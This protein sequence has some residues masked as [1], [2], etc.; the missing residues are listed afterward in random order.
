[1][2]GSATAACSS[3]LAASTVVMASF[4]SSDERVTK[5][6]GDGGSVLLG[7]GKD[8]AVGSGVGVGIT[9][10]AVGGS[11]DGLGDGVGTGDGSEV[12]VSSRGGVS[13][14]DVAVGWRVG[15]GRG[16]GEAVGVVGSIVAVTLAWRLAD[17]ELPIAGSITP[18]STAAR[19]PQT[20][21]QNSKPNSNA[22]MRPVTPLRLGLRT[23]GPIL[24]LPR[25]AASTRNGPMRRIVRGSMTTT[26]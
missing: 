26:R 14:V 6:V 18:L 17:G 23:I 16:V 5:G 19:P 25:S 3:S 7:S 11:G 22:P 8:V 4:T 20:T 10:V 9:S 24:C 13:G 15:D 12:G 2:L 1:M 21:S